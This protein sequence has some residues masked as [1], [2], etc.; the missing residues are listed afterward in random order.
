MLMVQ[1]GAE[2][3]ERHLLRETRAR[4]LP[5]GAVIAD[6]ILERYGADRMRVSE[7]GIREGLVLATIVSGASWRDRLESLAAGWQD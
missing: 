2:A 6:A 1:T 3:A 7:L 4:L 5:A